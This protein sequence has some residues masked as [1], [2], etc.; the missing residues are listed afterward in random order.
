MAKKFK[1]LLNLLTLAEDP[2]SGSTGD[3]YLVIRGG[4]FDMKDGIK[5]TNIEM[6]LSL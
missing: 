1:S 6:R 3:V 4:G 5:M 2:L